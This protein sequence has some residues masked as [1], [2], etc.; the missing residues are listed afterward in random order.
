M[1]GEKKW[2]VDGV[3]PILRPVLR[4]M[5]IEKGRQMGKH[6]CFGAERRKG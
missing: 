2:L 4:K 5:G 3:G 6:I 1:S